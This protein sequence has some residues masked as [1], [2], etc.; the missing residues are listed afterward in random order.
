MAFSEKLP[1]RQ[2]R[3]HLDLCR[4]SAAQAK[5]SILLE[6]LYQHLQLRLLYQSKLP[7]QLLCISNLM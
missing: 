5:S 4:M 7:D 3:V 6:S 2:Q 1:Q